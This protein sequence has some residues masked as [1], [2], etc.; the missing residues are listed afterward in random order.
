LNKMRAK[1]VCSKVDKSEGQET[2]YASPVVSGSEENKSFSK[3]T[4]SGSLSITITNPDAFG[5][6]SQGAEF[7]VDF[8]PDFISIGKEG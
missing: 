3:Y 1:F 6:I 5:F 8:T 4:P 2:V 7:Y